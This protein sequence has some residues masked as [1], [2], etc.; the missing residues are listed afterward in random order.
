MD[1]QKMVSNQSSLCAICGTKFKVKWG[2]D[3]PV[4]DHCHTHGNVRGI[5]CNECNRGLGYFH[6][7]TN[8]LANAI[9]YLEGEL[10]FHT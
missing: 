9:K 1:Y 3:A 8:A 2:P 10:P 6:D 5:L 7:N 4:I